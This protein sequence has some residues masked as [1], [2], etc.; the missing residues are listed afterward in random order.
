MAIT[1]LPTPP[2]R[3]DPTNFATRADAFMAALPAFA[4]ETNAVA[5]EVDND[6]IASAS[7]A[8]SAA[9]QVGLAQAQVALA[10]TQVGLATTQATNSA[11]SATASANSATSANNARVAA[12][13]ARDATLAAYDS[14]DDRYLGTKTTDP[15]VDND[16]NPLVAGALYFNSVSGVMKLY[17]G[18]A[19]VAAYVTGTGYLTASEN[20]NDLPNKSTARTNLG[21]AIGT[22]VQA[23]D[24]D[25]TA[26]AGKTAPTGDAVGSSDSQTLTNKTIA[27]ADNTLTGVQPSLVSGTN[28]KTI[29]STSVLGSG[30]IAIAGNLTYDFTLSESITQGQIVQL[31]ANGQIEKIAATNTTTTQTIPNGSVSSPFAESLNVIVKSDPRNAN[32]FIAVWRDASNGGYGTIALGTISGS[33][34]TWGSK[35][36]FASHQIGNTSYGPSYAVEF[37]PAQTDTFLISYRNDSNTSDGRVIAGQILAESPYFSFGTPVGNITYMVTNGM[38]FDSA[39]NG[40]A[41]V[42][43]K[44]DG[45]GTGKAF[46]VTVSGTTVS[47]G[48]TVDYG[49]AGYWHSVA[50]N[51]NASG[52]F[53]VVHLVSG[54]QCTARLATI[55]GTSVSFSSNTSISFNGP[56]IVKYDPKFSRF[57]VISSSSSDT[58]K[59][60]VLTL[61]SNTLNFYFES[62]FSGGNNA[63]VDV[64]PYGSGKFVTF[65]RNGSGNA[66]IRVIEMLTTSFSQVGSTIALGY[67]L[68]NY[69]TCTDFSP[70]GSGKFVTSASS[71]SSAMAVQLGQISTVVITTNLDSARILGAIESSGTSGTTRSVALKGGLTNKQTGLTVGS[72]Y[73]VLRDGSLSTTFTSTLPYAKLGR[74]VSST[75]ILLVGDQ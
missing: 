31:L 13:S 29:N 69:A 20:L 60:A 18:S 11:N 7:S 47:K 2:S 34:I 9:T 52:Q 63:S 74:A 49:S 15:S 37:D 16:G 32:R 48:T 67:G 57:L 61:I 51:P 4:T 45:T 59:Y 8:S 14:F 27:Y 12:E 66:E 64:D 70:I 62:Q 17:T 6:R 36:V 55:S 68:A 56:P 75:A 35:F 41:L 65:Y 22:N 43:Y 46:V 50:A 44:D 72:T 28:I 42:A 53:V 25:L 3:N 73:Y 5:V 71:S 39:R 10:T 21:L 19:W 23:Y 33:S 38:A 30:D 24:A 58:V 54:G 40:K 26:W 1:P